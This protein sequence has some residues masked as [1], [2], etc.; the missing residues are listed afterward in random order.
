MCVWV[1]V[2]YTQKRLT[3]F[4]DDSQLID[5]FTLDQLDGGRASGLASALEGPPE[6]VCRVL[7]PRYV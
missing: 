7:V 1:G 2:C 5:D 3:K 6:G 4:G